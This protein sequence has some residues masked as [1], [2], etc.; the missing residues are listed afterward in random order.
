[1]HPDRRGDVAAFTL[2]SER[3]CA[4]ASAS[5]PSLCTASRATV[6]PERV[7]PP[8]FSATASAPPLVRA[9]IRGSSRILGGFGRFEK[10]S[11]Q[12]PFTQPLVDLE[13]HEV[14]RKYDTYSQR[15]GQSPISSGV[16]ECVPEGRV[17]V[18]TL[19]QRF[20]HSFD[21]KEEQTGD[22]VEKH[23]DGD[24]DNPGSML[25]AACERRLVKYERR[26][27]SQQGANYRVGKYRYLN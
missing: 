9:N 10:Q 20:Q 2:A 17:K 21:T 6:Q 1:L 14:E 18:V 25:K 27:G 16:F 13:E 3:L 15:P 19:R 23:L 5:N 8:A 26:F 22:P 4:A 12:L 11:P 7:F 24:R